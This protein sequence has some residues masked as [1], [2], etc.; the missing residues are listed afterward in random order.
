MNWL[1]S[2][3]GATSRSRWGSC[4]PHHSPV[5]WSL[6]NKQ[7]ANRIPEPSRQD[8][9]TEPASDPHSRWLQP[10]SPAQKATERQGQKVPQRPATKEKTNPEMLLPWHIQ[11]PK[12]S[13][14]LAEPQEPKPA[15]QAA[16]QA[17]RDE[18]LRHSKQV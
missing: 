7:G 6:E 9:N 14:K 2:P 5:K 12:S 18:P 8:P 17:R 3:W 16:V 13:E 11:E 15:L 1:A 10:G 4:F